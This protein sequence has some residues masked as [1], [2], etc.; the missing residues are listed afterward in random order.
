MSD[1]VVVL[2]VKSDGLDIV[3][4]TQEVSLDRVRIGGLAEDLQKSWVRHEEE[5]REDETFL[6]QVASEG[7]LAEF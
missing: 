1:P 4:D 7:L 6:L 5:T 2:L 3:K